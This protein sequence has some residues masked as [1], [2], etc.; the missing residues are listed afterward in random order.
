[1]VIQCCFPVTDTSR[2]KAPRAEGNHPDW[3]S[4]VRA[5]SGFARWGGGGGGSQH[6]WN[7]VRDLS[8]E[9]AAWE[10][11]GKLHPWQAFTLRKENQCQKGNPHWD[12]CLLYSQPISASILVK[13]SKF[14]HLPK[15]AHS[16]CL[17]Q[18][19]TQKSCKVPTLPLL[20]DQRKPN[21]NSLLLTAELPKSFSATCHQ[22]LVEH[23]GCQTLQNSV[24]EQRE[25]S[26]IS[27]CTTSSISG[28]SPLQAQAK[29]LLLLRTS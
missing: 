8:T 7:F 20:P 28:Q 25:V 2:N 21:L 27:L 18:N 12:Q 4:V 9:P 17:W 14:H 15:W 29:Y 11:G 24:W 3:L 10:S 23:F 13:L 26:S 1:M 16:S 22:R 19:Q 6:R 5:V